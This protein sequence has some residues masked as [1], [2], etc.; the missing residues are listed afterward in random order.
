MNAAP[1]GRQG[2]VC[3]VL[4]TAGF[5]GQ[6]LS[7][8]LAAAIFTGLGGASAGLT[9]AAA[10]DGAVSLTHVVALQHTFLAAFKGALLACAG[11]GAV[12][13]L[14]ALVRGQDRGIAR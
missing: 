5:V 4:A 11:L 1:A 10:R 3:G 6:S 9:L 8:A 12:G 7:V 14:A 2:E 13:I